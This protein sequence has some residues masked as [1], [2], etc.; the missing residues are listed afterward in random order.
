VQRGLNFILKRTSGLYFRDIIRNQQEILRRQEALAEQLR[1]LERSRQMVYLGDHKVLTRMASGHKIVLDSRDRSLF[2]HITFEGQW[3]SWVTKAMRDNLRP[4][5]TVV[6]AGANVGYFTLIA[7]DS[8]GRE[9]RVFAF[10]PDPETFEM[11]FRNVE[12]NGYRPICQCH[13]VALSSMRGTATFYRFSVHFGGNSLWHTGGATT[14]IRDE[15]AEVQV[16]TIAFDDFAEDAGIG[17]VDLI[18][19]DTEGSEAH[20]LQG[21]RKTLAANTNIV[22]LCEFNAER[23]RSSNCDPETS[24]DSIMEAGFKLRLVNYDGSIREISR[25]EVL[26]HPDAMLFLKRS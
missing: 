22:L 20:V 4:G 19:I 21:M 13:R 25:A 17:T 7:C 8:V 24:V 18:K 15:V 26:T 10:E 2:P 11:L 5:M 16:D 23:I 1:Q 3:E 9:G 6:D 14:E 12:M